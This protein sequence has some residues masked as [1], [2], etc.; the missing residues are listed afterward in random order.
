MCTSELISSP[1]GAQGVQNGAL[2]LLRDLVIDVVTRNLGR[3]ISSCETRARFYALLLDVGTM[4]PEG[5]APTSCLEAAAHL[6]LPI[7]ARAA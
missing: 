7:C 1:Q 6:D 3:H 2:G 5:R 4:F